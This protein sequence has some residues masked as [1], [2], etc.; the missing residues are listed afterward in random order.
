M[1]LVLRPRRRDLLRLSEAGPATACSSPGIRTRNPRILDPPPLP[2]GPES[3]VKV[4]A[5]IRDAAQIR[6]T[7][8]WNPL[9][10]SEPRCRLR[11]RPKGGGGRIRYRQLFPCRV[12]S[13]FGPPH[14]TPPKN[15]TS[16]RGFGDRRATGTPVG[17]APEQLRARGSCRSGRTTRLGGELVPPP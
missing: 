14:R 8:T 10:N 17:F 15:R 16:S 3:H 2:V 5:R 11:Q 6:R 7:R 4:A 12:A 9:M 1:V 13:A